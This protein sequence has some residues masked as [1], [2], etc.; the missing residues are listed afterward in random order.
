[1]TPTLYQGIAAASL[2]GLLTGAAMQ[3][4][5]RAGEDPAGPQMLSGVSGARSSTDWGDITLRNWN[6]PV[7]DYVVG[8][9][10]L[11]PV[12]YGYDI[13]F[14]DASADYDDWTYVEPESSFDDEPRQPVSWEMAEATPASNPSE[15]GDILGGVSEAPP[16]EPPLEADVA[17]P[18]A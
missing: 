11:R 5:L 10:S 16:L 3:P 18:S 15:T 4:D 13:A 1:M 12:E 2:A 6:G 9:D 8:T 17:P 7:P 14:S